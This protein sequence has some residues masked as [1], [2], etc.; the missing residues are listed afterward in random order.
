[1]KSNEHTQPCQAPMSA[2]RRRR[3]PN[4]AVREAYWYA[5]RLH[6][7]GW[8]I[9]NLWFNGSGHFNGLTPTHRAIQVDCAGRE[10]VE[11]LPTEFAYSI[12]RLGELAELHRHDYLQDL[13]IFLGARAPA[14]RPTPTT[15]SYWRIPG[16][17][18]RRQPRDIVRAAYWLAATLTDD[19][20]WEL[21]EIGSALSGWGF[22]AHIPDATTIAYPVDMADDGTTAAMLARMI[23]ELSLSECAELGSLISWHAKARARLG[24]TPV[25]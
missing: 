9:Y 22:L 12:R 15:K 13:R 6:N 1:M 18:Q 10:S 24:A 25:G 19:Y 14:H 2:L 11:D 8:Q 23:G 5:T 16:L 4:A 20:A 21:S 3:Q 7:H 17:P